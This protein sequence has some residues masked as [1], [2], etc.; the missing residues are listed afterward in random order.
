MALG[1]KVLI[2]TSLVWVMIVATVRT[3]RAE[4][5][6]VTGT[7]DNFLAKITVPRGVDTIVTNPPFVTGGRLAARFIEHAIGLAPIVA[8]LL[9]IDFDSGRTHTH[10]FRDNSHF[11][12]KIV[13]LH[14]I[15]WFEREGAP[16]QP[17]ENHRWMVWDLRHRGPPTIAYASNAN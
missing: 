12:Q 3:L 14:R 6:R 5:F 13:F 17:S 8:M 16:E 10:L 1:W 15:V 4:G 2:P 9:R 7:A 11:A